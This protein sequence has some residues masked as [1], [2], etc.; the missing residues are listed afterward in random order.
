MDVDSLRAELEQ[1]L[2]KNPDEDAPGGFRDRFDIVADRY[3]AGDGDV[4][5]EALEAQL[6]Q[7]RNEAEAA[8]RA[9]QA[10]PAAGAEAAAPD[11]RPRAESG[12]TGA[13]DVPAAEPGGLLSRFG[14]PLVLILVVVAAAYFFLR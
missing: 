2:D 6:Q 8:W 7:I 11:G 9:C 13:A 14:L 5:K 1:Q 3:A 10:D 4:P 12:D